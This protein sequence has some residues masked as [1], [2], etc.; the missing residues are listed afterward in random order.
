[1]RRVHGGMRLLIA[2]S[3]LFAHAQQTPTAAW[4]TYAD[5][6]MRCPGLM[7]FYTLFDDAPKQPD[8]SGSDAVLTYRPH[9]GAPLATEPGRI[10]GRTAVVLDSACFEAAPVHFPSN[11][12]TVTLWV[13]PL[14]TG[15][16]TGNGG[17]VNGMLV[18][19][20]SGYTDGW[21]LA[22]YDWK[23]RHP[24]FEIGREKGAVS[25]RANDP[26]SAGFWNHLA[27]TWDGTCMRL[28][29]N[30]TL[31]AEKPYDGVLIPPKSSLKIGFAN[32][33][34]GS[35]RMAV[36]ECALFD[37]ALPATMLASFSLNGAPLSATL[38]G[39]VRTLQETA[40]IPERDADFSRAAQEIASNTSAPAA[41]RHW[42]ALNV[43]RRHADTMTCAARV[44]DFSVPAHLRGMAVETLAQAVRKGVELPSRVLVKLPEF[45]ELDADDQRQ[46]AVAL[47]DAYAR[48]GNVDAASA[49]F[50]QL[51]S[52]S[53]VLPTDAAEVRQ[54][55][56]R[57][58]RQA[59]RLEEAG[60]HYAA[61]RDDSRLPASIRAIAALGLAQ[62]W[63]Q[64]GNLEQAEM[65]FREAAGVT[66]A[67]PHVADEARACAEACANLRAGRP[68]RDPEANRRRLPEFPTP[69]V[70][71]Y[72]APK[73]DDHGSGS[74]E[75]PFA[76]LERARDAIRAQRKNGVLPRGGVTVYL[77][78]GTYPVT[79][80]FTLTEIDSGNSGAPVVYRAWRDERPV[81]DGGFRVRRLRAVRDKD[82]LAR[83]PAEARGRVRM[84][85]LKEQG[86]ASFPPQR[87]FGYGINNKTVR[88]LFEDGQP[89]IP[90]RWPNSGTVMTG[91]V[92]DPTN[93]VF[94]FTSERLARW[95]Q[96]KDIMANGYWYH[97]WAVCAV[98]VGA[99]AATRTLTLKE[100][101]GGYGVRAD[102]PFYVFNLLEEID[103]PGE[104]YMD[105][106][107]GKLYVWP[108]RHPWFSTLV[109]SRWDK[110]FIQA[111][112]VRDVIFHGLTFEYG[113]Q[114]GL[115]LNGC[116]NVTVAGC[117]VRRLGGSAIIAPNS[118][119]LKLYGNRLH[120]LGHT[121]MHVGGGNRRNLTSGQVQIENNEVH[122]FGRCSRTYN[123]AVLLEGCGARV[124][125]NH[126]HH[127]PSS[128]M[129]IEGNDHLIEYNDVHHVVQESDDQGGIDM[130]GNPAY[131]GVVIRFNRWRDIGGGAHVPC[132]QAGIRFDDAISG[133][134]VYGNLFERASNGHFG[135]VQI[136]GGHNN[137]IDNNLFIDCRY[138]VSFS[139]WGQKRWEEFL[140]RDTIQRL[141]FT[142]VDIR[143]P[144]Y[145][146]RYPELADLG[147]RADL[148]SIWR[149]VFV[150]VEESCFKKPKGTDTWDNLSVATLPKTDTGA[151]SVFCA[152]P[153]DEI[154]TYDDPMRATG[155]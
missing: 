119:N 68:A 33:G 110:P 104:W 112:R 75:Q 113:Q 8:R 114:H 42:S 49:V 66:H 153:L 54:R 154:G 135:G 147:T 16:Q 124:A 101:P 146:R 9:Q 76:T 38:S 150:N 140:A 63:R 99:D 74:F 123:P 103:Q 59:G 36:D 18:C 70:A 125:H 138:G 111:D 127:A 62:T 19:S 96:A 131:R 20:G 67:P 148:N 102:H 71:F 155:E 141:M 117:V 93:F 136:H 121:G 91:T 83:L 79:N 5:D 1:M 37:R 46:F 116:V 17:S 6:V 40:L 81:F 84:A 28:Y 106:E 65:A 100:R 151:A 25:I 31:S 57:I 14:G 133:M 47:A 145:S 139:P 120:T 118:A 56:A 45:L 10:A 86:Y 21:R 108:T 44:D 35:L 130:W 85:D 22:V 24:S 137:I 134:L 126:F 11:A 15:T 149:N 78:G 13:R 77:R 27:A 23:S 26:L 144:P 87:S 98:P 55:C 61:V 52:F 143:Q 73:G 152:L 48:E 97:L 109:L 32:Y 7:R 2:T 43:A 30:G 92:L 51:L 132:G 142:D 50:N 80:T 72:V 95:S 88:E 39:Q 122:H 129:R 41:W 60:T 107:T 90:A 3:A 105:S 69:A 34:V 94:S 29:V 53:D 82:V 115:V 64:A 4:Q 12:F 128:A 89:L 58:L